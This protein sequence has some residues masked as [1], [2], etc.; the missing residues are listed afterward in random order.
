[1]QSDVIRR[2]DIIKEFGSHPLIRDRLFYRLPAMLLKAIDQEVGR[3]AFDPNVI[4]LDRALSE[5]CARDPQIVGYDNGLPIT[6][7]L[8][9]GDGCGPLQSIEGLTPELASDADRLFD[10]SNRIRRNYAG[11]L[12]VNRTYIDERDK[13]CARWA[14]RIS[15]FGLPVVGLGL[16][17][18]LRRPALGKLTHNPQLKAFVEE[19]AE[20]CGRWRLNGLTT[21]E[22]PVPLSPQLG[23]PATDK[24]PPALLDTA[25][26]T[27]KPSIFPA[28]FGRDIDFDERRRRRT[29]TAHLTDWLALTGP[30]RSNDQQMDRYGRIFRLQHFWRVLAQRHPNLLQHRTK[31]AAAFAEFLGGVSLRTIQSD[32]QDISSQ[33]GLP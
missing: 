6:Y 27:W 18:P 33:V 29:E 19:F 23:V 14:Q 9:L 15:E 30:E 21:P 28:S 8:L 10:E 17:A 12:M 16:S 7:D 13:Y 11:W 22:L 25:E 32:L 31:L 20:F 3:A 4:E 2:T 1:M 26:L 5:R 24:L